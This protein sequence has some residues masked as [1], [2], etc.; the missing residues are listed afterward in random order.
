[1]DPAR[2]RQVAG[3]RVK[4]ASRMAILGRASLL[5]A[6][7]SAERIS[8]I[9]ASPAIASPAHGVARDGEGP[10]CPILGLG[11]GAREFEFATEGRSA[12]TEPEAGKHG[13]GRGWRR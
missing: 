3:Q 13:D 10:G 11:E 7:T 4:P 8:T 1:M 9:A 12:N 6:L 2:R 5:Q